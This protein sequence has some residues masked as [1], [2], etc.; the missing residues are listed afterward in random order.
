LRHDGP[1]IGQLSL[2]GGEYSIAGENGTGLFEPAAF[3]FKPESR[4]TSCWKG[5]VCAYALRGDQLVLD[6]LLIN[7]GEW[8]GRQYVAAPPIVFNGRQPAPCEKYDPFD[9]QYSNVDLAVPFTGGLLLGADF[10][11][12]LYVHMGF[13][14]AWKYRKVRELLFADGK[15]QSQRDVST[16]LAEIRT[17][18]RNRSMSPADKS[19][20]E[21][22]AWIA[23]TFSLSYEGWGLQVE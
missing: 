17:R 10:I 19:D 3:G 2:R 20:G 4:I 9:H 21:V 16:Q 5:Y 23:S 22:E 6:G 18:F 12:E 13:H 14:P 1:G 8:R 11:R 7:H 15:L